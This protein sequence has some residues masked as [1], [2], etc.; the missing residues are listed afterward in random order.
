MII[1][2]F[3]DFERIYGRGVTNVMI[4][5]NVVLRA[6]AEGKQ[7]S[8]SVFYGQ[9]FGDQANLKTDEKFCLSGPY[10]V[11]NLEELREKVPLE[12]SKDEIF[13]AFS[14][15]KLVI[16]GDSGTSVHDVINVVYVFRK[17]LDRDRL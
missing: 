17:L 6:P 16:E 13:E 3:L 1:A 15:R 9:S 4:T 11:K 5:A 10:I 2:E 8:Y 12:C 14:D 7:S